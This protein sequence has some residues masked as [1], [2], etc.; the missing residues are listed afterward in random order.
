M[1]VLIQ[2]AVLVGTLLGSSGQV[3]GRGVPVAWEGFDQCEFYTAGPSFC[4]NQ[5]QCFWDYKEQRCAWK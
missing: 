1:K 2:T 5:L 4:N 3:V